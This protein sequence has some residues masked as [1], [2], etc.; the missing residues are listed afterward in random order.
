MHLLATIHCTA[1]ALYALSLIFPPRPGQDM[2]SAAQIASSQHLAKGRNNL[3][4][5]RQLAL[6]KGEEQP[7]RY[8]VAAAD[9]FANV[10]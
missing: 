1:Y 8:P 4:G 2:C 9:H 7:W 5:S 6:G 3:L 10:F